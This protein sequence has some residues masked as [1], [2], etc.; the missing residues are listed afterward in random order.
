MA[1]PS[2][3]DSGFATRVEYEKALA[4]GMAD[5]AVSGGAPMEL[6]YWKIRGLAAALR[7]MFHF[8]STSFKLE[9]GGNCTTVH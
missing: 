8:K 1:P 7:M 3:I 6:G 5:C 2:F 4:S 9:L